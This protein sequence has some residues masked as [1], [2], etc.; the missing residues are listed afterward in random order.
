MLFNEIAVSFNPKVEVELVVMILQ[1]VMM[2]LKENY[3]E[4][5]M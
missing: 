2:T 3:Q 4:M 5:V 1:V